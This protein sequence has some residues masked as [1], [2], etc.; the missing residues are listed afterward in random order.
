[1]IHY[2]LTCERQHQFDGW[3][4][5]ASAY[6][7]QRETGDLVC[8][9]CG[10]A[11]IGKGLMA[12]AVARSGSGKVDVVLPAAEQAQ[13]REMLR[14]L[15]DKVVSTAENV[16]PNFAIEARKIHYAEAPSRGIY[17]QASG[18][19]VAELLDEG[20]EFMPLPEFPDDHN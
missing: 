11:E 7:A 19:E 12:P 4:K 6:D 16:G 5:S 15:R 20:I 17:G 18:D 9:V 10:S 14:A 8:P 13:I 2:T 1:M 3:F